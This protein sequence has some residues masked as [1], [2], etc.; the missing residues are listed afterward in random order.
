M[1]FCIITP[2]YNRPEKLKRAVNS[3]L[4]QSYTDFEMIIVNDSPEDSSYRDIA[5]EIKKDSRI[6][7]LVNDSNSGVNFSRNRALDVL[8]PDTNWVIFL[9]DDDY[10]AIDA[11]AT[12]KILIETQPDEAWF[13]TNRAYANGAPITMSPKNAT[14]Y[15]YA[16][17]YLI[18][19]RIKGDATHCIR[20]EKIRSIR[21]PTLIK[22]AEEWLFFFQLGT[23]AKPFYHNFNSTLSDG[24]AE[25]GLNYRRRTAS[26]QLGT[27]Y[28][29]IK[30]GAHR[31][32][33]FYPSFIVYIC[34]RWLR[35]FIK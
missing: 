6:K 17:D 15:S 19:K 25:T 20:A 28:L 3:V 22:Q 16:W 14:S 1:K 23:T 24:Y 33:I 8:S 4:S 18:T 10:L 21:F 7:Y 27:F 32:L 13:M 26:E 30:E 34:M 29:I 9:D 11:L 2:T 35:I 12:F 5:L 31:G